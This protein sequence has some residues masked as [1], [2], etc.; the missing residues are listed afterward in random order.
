MPVRAW[1]DTCNARRVDGETEV[2]DAELATLRGEAAISASCSARRR[3][4]WERAK[5]GMSMG[6]G[7]AR[8]V[9]DINAVWNSK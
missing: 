6:T 7:V 8:D 1:P 9:E 4:C 3:R 2:V 5:A